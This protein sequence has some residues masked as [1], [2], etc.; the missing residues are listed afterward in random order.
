MRTGGVVN[1]EFHDVR[2]LTHLIR[3]TLHDA[4]HKH[5]HYLLC[6]LMLVLY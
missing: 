2:E 1:D 5:A 6:L 3:E 4:L